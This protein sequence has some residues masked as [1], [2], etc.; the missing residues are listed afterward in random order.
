VF[1]AL[2]EFAGEVDPRDTFMPLPVAVSDV[3]ERLLSGD[4]GDSR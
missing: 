2:A 1:T 3:V 4:G